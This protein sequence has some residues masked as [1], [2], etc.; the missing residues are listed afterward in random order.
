[1][2]AVLFVYSKWWLFVDIESGTVFSYRVVGFLIAEPP[3]A[4]GET[5]SMN[6]ESFVDQM[7]KVMRLAYYH[8]ISS[9]PFD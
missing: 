2:I 9:S 6:N 5:S 4:R 7:W 1:M 8:F 3:F